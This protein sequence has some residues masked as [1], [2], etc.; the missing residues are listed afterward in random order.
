MLG[1]IEGRRRKEILIHTA[2]WTHLEDMMRREESQ[3]QRWMMVM[4]VQQCTECHH[5][6]K[7]V[8]ME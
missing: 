7:M 6:L 8:K 4:V 1:K 3:L 5:H 2:K